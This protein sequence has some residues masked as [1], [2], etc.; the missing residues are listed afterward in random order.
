MNPT[1]STTPDTTSSGATKTLSTGGA[2]NTQRSRGIRGGQGRRTTTTSGGNSTSIRATIFK[3]ST[4]GMHGNIFQRYEEQQDRQ[5]CAKTM[6][7]LEAYVKK[8]LQ[9][10]EDLAIFF[11][12]EMTNPIINE[13]DDLEDMPTEF[14]KRFL[15]RK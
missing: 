10:P 1:P 6:E 4:D 9:Y 12:T 5:Q 13:P 14:K 15:W 2:S 7:A 11:G 3:G 8:N